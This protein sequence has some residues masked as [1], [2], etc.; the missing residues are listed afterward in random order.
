MVVPYWDSW[1]RRVLLN[2]MTSRIPSVR[3]VTS[4]L[5]GPVCFTFGS[6]LQVKVTCLECFFFWQNGN[7]SRVILLTDAVHKT[8]YPFYI[9]FMIFFFPSCRY[10]CSRRTM[11]MSPRKLILDCTEKPLVVTPITSW[12]MEMER[13]L[14]GSRTTWGLME[15]IGGTTTWKHPSERNKLSCSPISW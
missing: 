13:Q 3:W 9:L 2:V 12:L 11:T 14:P 5:S 1:C 6:H 15:L 7:N 10:P 8:R 4:D